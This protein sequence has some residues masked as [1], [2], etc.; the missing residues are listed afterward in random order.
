MSVGVFDQDISAAVSLELPQI[1][2]RGIRQK[3]FRVERFWI[4]MGHGVY[5][6][7][8]CYFGVYLMT[9]DNASGSS[10]FPVD[11][12]SFS[13]ILSCCALFIINIFGTANWYTWSWINFFSLTASMLSWAIF[14]LSYCSSID[15]LPYG[16]TPTLS[17]VLI[18]IIVVA[19]SLLPRLVIKF[20]Q[21]M[22]FPNDTDILQ[23]YQQY[24]SSD[25][26]SSL[27]TFDLHHHI[28]D[29]LAKTTAENTTKPPSPAKDLTRKQ[30]VPQNIVNADG[31][32]SSIVPE[33]IDP[34]TEELKNIVI[35][36][37][38]KYRAASI[39]QVINEKVQ[40]AGV[41]FKTLLPE[42]NAPSYPMK[43]KG[44]IAYMAGDREMVENKGFAFSHDAG[45]QDVIT[46][47]QMTLPPIPEDNSHLSSHFKRRRFPSFVPD[48]FRQFSK[49]AMQKLGKSRQST[50]SL[51]EHIHVSGERPPSP[52]TT[53]PLPVPVALPKEFPKKLH[54]KR[55]SF[56]S[57]SKQMFSKNAAGAKSHENIR[58]VDISAELMKSA[59]PP[60]ILLDGEK[61]DKSDTSISVPNEPKSPGKTRAASSHIPDRASVSNSSIGDGRLVKKSPLHHSQPVIFVSEPG[62][63]SDSFQADSASGSAQIQSGQ[64]NNAHPD[65]PVIA[66]TSSENNCPSGPSSPSESE[67]EAH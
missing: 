40:K 50:E 66:A 6:S 54:G 21:R 55:A 2:L 41:F 28:K 67:D 12:A 34:K 16:Y 59:S 48:R 56:S 26:H 52:S 37:T 24:G 18:I 64:D 17:L 11:G 62:E 57:F 43:K 1:Y 39:G 22:M 3:D 35:A 7:L 46:P 19:L 25:V 38:E 15:T 60:S 61:I 42:R 9:E 49:K 5:Q 31:F 10:G 53:P 65:G 63:L 36:E 45:M 13:I 8:V 29:L 20:S 33:A 14:L 51:G 23:E 4:Y 30:S 58:K 44:S 47:L 27:V 32:E